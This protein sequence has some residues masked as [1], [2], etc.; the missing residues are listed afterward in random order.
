[1]GSGDLAKSVADTRAAALDLCQVLR[2]KGQEIE[3]LQ[4]D[5]CSSEHYADPWLLWIRPADGNSWQLG[6]SLV[7]GLSDLEVVMQPFRAIRGIPRVDIILHSARLLSLASVQAWKLDLEQTMTSKDLCTE[8]DL[9]K[10]DRATETVKEALEYWKIFKRFGELWEDPED[11]CGMY[12]SERECHENNRERR[13]YSAYSTE[14]EF[15]VDD[16]GCR[17]RKREYFT[18]GG[19]ETEDSDSDTVFGESDGEG[20]EEEVGYFNGVRVDDLCS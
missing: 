16:P 14:S 2:E 18:Y 13:K 17:R 11:T 20:K 6:S 15:S 7:D 12:D 9:Q 10:L 1:M 4:L 5:I 8:H 19:S 3:Y